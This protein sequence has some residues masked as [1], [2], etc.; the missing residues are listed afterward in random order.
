MFTG[1]V[2]VGNRQPFKL[3]GLVLCILWVFMLSSLLFIAGLGKIDVSSSCSSAIVALYPPFTLY[4][5]ELIAE[6][7]QFVQ[8]LLRGTVI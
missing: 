1:Y 6:Q 4:A 5:K 2:N 8:I 7:L 3:E